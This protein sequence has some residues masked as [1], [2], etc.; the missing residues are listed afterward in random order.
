MLVIQ[1]KFVKVILPLI[2]K[3]NFDAKGNSVYIIA[4][5]FN[6]FPRKL[7]VFLSLQIT[8]S[9]KLC[10]LELNPSPL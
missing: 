1:N 7:N 5:W 4:D 2:S 3:S 6:H 9:I 10:K 8:L